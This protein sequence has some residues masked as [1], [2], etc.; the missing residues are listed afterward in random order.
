MADTRL[1]K[2]SLSPWPTA[3]IFLQSLPSFCLCVLQSFQNVSSDLF[4]DLFFKKKKLAISLPLPD[5]IT[6]GK[7]NLDAIN[8]TSDRGP[9]FRSWCVY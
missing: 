5:L 8:Y 9:N 7:I 2:L 3:Q 1:N 4:L 6:V